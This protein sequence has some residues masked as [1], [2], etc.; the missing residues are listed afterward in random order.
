MILLQ[1]ATRLLLAA[2]CITITS[3]LGLSQNQPS[4]QGI[5]SFINNRDWTG[6]IRYATNWTQADPRSAKAWYYLG[7]AYFTAGKPEN[8][9]E[10]LGKATMLDP[11]LK[12]AWMGLGFAND[13]LN[14]FADA[15]K[16]FEHCLLM[17][18]RPAD[19]SNAVIAYLNANQPQQ[20]LAILE[21]QRTSG[22]PLDSTGWYNMGIAFDALR[23][24]GDARGCYQQAVQLNPQLAPA[25]NNLGVIEQNIGNTEAAL[26]DYQRAASLGE[27]LGASNGSNLRSGIA[28]AQQR[29]GGRQVTPQMVRE[30]VRQGQAKAWETNH[31]GSLAQPYGHP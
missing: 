11:N 2:V 29:V 7:T 22:N 6:A 20:A 8:A 26:Q 30:F 9:V 23:R 10:P 28:A 14:R 18:P 25:W 3:S 12:P 4:E 24:T 1:K 5:I 21:K 16:A 27:T 13:R 19:Y 15:A 17:S 31:P